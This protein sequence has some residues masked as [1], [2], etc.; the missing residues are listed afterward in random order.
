MKAPSRRA[1]LGPSGFT[2]IELLVVIAIIAILIALLVPAVQ[3]VREAASR[4]TCENNLR[5][6]VL[7]AHN[8]HTDNKIFPDHSCRNDKFK[9]DERQTWLFQILPYLEKQDIYN[10]ALTDPAFY[11]TPIATFLCPSD[12]RPLI[13]S[14]SAL[15][16]APGLPPAKYAMTSYLGICGRSIEDISLPGG[17]NGVIG[18]YRPVIIKGVQ[19]RRSAKLKEISDGTSNTVM[20]GERPPGGSGHYRLPP[21]DR[22]PMFWGWWCSYYDGDCTTWIKM[23]NWP[24]MTDQTGKPCPSVVYPRPGDL[25]NDCDVNHLWSTHLGGAMFGFADGSIRFMEYSF[26]ATIL[27]KLATRNGDEPDG[28]L[29]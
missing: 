28:V 27:P 4:T 14:I 9:L 26:G 12:P 2:L 25:E 21:A 8:Y 1:S 22:D 23:V 10:A 3:K 19:V 16:S 13:D 20:I 29:P 6:I 11:K 7:A 17:D 5:Q 15:Y 24:N 18:C